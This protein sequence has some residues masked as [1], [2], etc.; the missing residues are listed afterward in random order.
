MKKAVTNQDVRAALNGS[1][2]SARF[3]VNFALNQF[4]PRIARQVVTLQ[5]AGVSVTVAQSLGVDGFIVN[6]SFVAWRELGVEARIAEAQRQAEFPGHPG[7]PV[8]CQRACCRVCGTERGEHPRW[9][10]NFNEQEG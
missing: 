3:V 10:E 1:D 6:G 8:T 7:H 5:R 9:C 2:P 4:G